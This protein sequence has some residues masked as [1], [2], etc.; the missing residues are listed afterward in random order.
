MFWLLLSLF[1]LSLY[2]KHVHVT[3]N[4]APPLRVSHEIMIIKLDLLIWHNR[5]LSV[6]RST[7]SWDRKSVAAFGGALP[8]PSFQVSCL[9]LTVCVVFQQAFNGLPSATLGRLW[10]K[11]YEEEDFSRWWDLTCPPFFAPCSDSKE[12][13]KIVITYYF[14]H[15]KL[16]FFMFH[17]C[18]R[19]DSFPDYPFVIIS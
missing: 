2:N 1:L 7:E 17:S 10:S 11:C 12:A 4:F 5:T 14:H 19:L 8:H 16:L 18:Q 6:D 15:K 9:L 13:A 3:S